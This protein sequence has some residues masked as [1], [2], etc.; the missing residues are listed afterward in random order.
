M[1]KQ[2]TNNNLKQ[3]I[4]YIII[5]IFVS[6]NSLLAQQG[7]FL[8]IFNGGNYDEGIAAFHLPDNTYRLIG[9]T[10][11]YGW[12]NTNIWFIAL[13]SSAHF[14][15]HKTIGRGGLDKA[16]DAVMDSKGN[17]FIVGSSTSESN[18]SYQMLFVGIDTSGVVFTNNYYGG[19]DWDFGHALCLV[20]DSLLMLA[21]ETYS[22]GNGQSDAWMLKVNKQGDSI[23]SNTI[24]GARKD[25]FKDVKFKADYGYVFAGKTQSYGNGSYN[26]MLY[27][28][29]IYGDSLWLK[30]YADTT[31]GGLNALLI[32]SD[33]TIITVGYQVDTDNVY[34]D[35]LVLKYQHNGDFVWNRTSLK[36]GETSNFTSIISKDNN[37]LAV[38]KTTA[39]GN[40]GEDMLG[41]TFSK[42]GW[43]KSNFLYGS[44]KDEYSYSINSDT[45]SGKYYLLVGTT[46]GYG[47]SHTGI[48]FLRLNSELKC[49]TTSSIEIPSSINSTINYN[50][51]EIQIYPNPFSSEVVI[52][53]LSKVFFGKKDITIVDAFGKVIFH[54]V[55]LKNNNKYRIKTNN[56]SKGVY[57][58]IVK[59]KLSTYSKAIIKL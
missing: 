40:G 59:S 12:G 11:S 39:Y 46:N 16:E 13:D 34:S 35:L 38:G 51:P 31:D 58:I 37:I 42:D 47:L 1:N 54:T 32:N 41:T 21:G 57:Y 33:T 17:I 10:G 7:T 18:M 50:K 56:L 9:N 23:W 53:M 8:R 55:D 28:T 43:Y 4:S 30:I 5:L 25:I 22:F 24:G 45:I 52:N 44:D 19:S 3:I 26:P 49:D 2:Q 20:D 6:V 15:W 48:I 36:F 27:H 29:D 14:M